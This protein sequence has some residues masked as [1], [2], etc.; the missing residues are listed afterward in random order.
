MPRIKCP[1]CGY[2]FNKP[3]D[4]SAKVM[5]MITTYSKESQKAIKGVMR[6]IYDNV[7]SD[8]SIEAYYYFLKG[9]NHY[10][11]EHIRYGIRVFSSKAYY[12]EGKGF[13]YLRSIIRNR[14]D[15]YS[16]QLKNERQL[17]GKSPKKRILK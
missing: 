12:K 13:F 10:E 17:H 8:K 1:C 16:K 4:M 7:P 14:V 9:I 5:K 11:E 3:T 2:D 15:N 6:N